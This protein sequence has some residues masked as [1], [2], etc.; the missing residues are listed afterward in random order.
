M[1]FIFEINQCTLDLE[2][3]S[4]GHFSSK[5]EIVHGVRSG[6]IKVEM[7]LINHKKWGHTLLR[8]QLPSIS[9]I[10]K[11][12]LNGYGRFERYHIWTERSPTD[13]H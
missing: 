4:R 2:R 3:G 5:L 6:I 9:R 11:N 13:Q 12:G 8:R 1:I 10:L 7:T